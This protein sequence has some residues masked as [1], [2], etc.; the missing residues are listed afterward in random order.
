[1]SGRII[2]GQSPHCCNG[3]CPDEGQIWECDECGAWWRL[4]MDGSH[5]K[6]GPLRRWMIRRKLAAQVRRKGDG[7]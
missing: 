5:A 2:Y 4:T 7:A 1:M 3:V 6:A